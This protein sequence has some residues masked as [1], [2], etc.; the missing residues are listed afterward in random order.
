MRP[1][2]P[3]NKHHVFK[4]LR[5]DPNN[6][7]LESA[8]SSGDNAPTEPAKQASVFPNPVVV[9]PVPGAAFRDL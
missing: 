9:W 8:A 6:A 7:I 1:Y 3:K 2:R 5:V 4:R